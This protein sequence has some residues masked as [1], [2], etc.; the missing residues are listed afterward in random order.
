M[1]FES[2]M[3]KGVRNFSEAVCSVVMNIPQGTTLS[4]AAVAKKAGFPGAARAVG[5]LMRR[6]YDKSVPCHRVIRSDGRLGEYNRGDEEAKA[7]RLVEEGV[8]AEK[9]VIKQGRYVW[10]VV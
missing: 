3:Q 6:N 5:S 4:Y 1:T 8:R 10:Y 7:K 2:S 9:R